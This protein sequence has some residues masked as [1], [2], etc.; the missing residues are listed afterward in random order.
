M[1]LA[2]KP[3]TAL[4]E[5]V[6]RQLLSLAALERLEPE[7]HVAISGSGPVVAPELKLGVAAWVAAMDRRRAADAPQ[8]VGA[9]GDQYNV[10]QDTHKKRQPDELARQ[11]P[12]E[13]EQRQ[14]E[15]GWANEAKRQC[16]AAKQARA[17][18]TTRQS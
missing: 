18:L 16:L 17:A 12:K 4:Q 14:K 8:V 6:C 10:H 15:Q 11:D 2:A 13:L 7:G 5:K 1:A 3:E 9:G